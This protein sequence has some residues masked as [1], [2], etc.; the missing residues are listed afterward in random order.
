[1]VRAAQT[2]RQVCEDGMSLV[3][4]KHT[5]AGCVPCE[6]AA[7]RADFLPEQCVAVVAAAAAA[8]QMLYELHR[9]SI[10]TRHGGDTP[11]AQLQMTFDDHELLCALPLPFCLFLFVR[12]LANHL[13][14]LAFFTSVPCHTTCLSFTPCRFVLILILLFGAPVSDSNGSRCTSS[15]RHTKGCSHEGHTWMH[16]T[17]PQDR[18]CF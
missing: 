2:Q 5:G 10:G 16:L 12:S 8:A 11:R 14:T 9:A 4:E 13:N 3:L 7:V 18:W 6:D 1:M 17:T 15:A